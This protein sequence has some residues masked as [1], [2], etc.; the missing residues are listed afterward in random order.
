MPSPAL[1]YLELPGPAA[2]SGTPRRLAWWDW[3]A[4]PAVESGHVVLCVHGLSRQ[5]RDFDALAAVLT[6]RGYEPADITVMKRL[7]HGN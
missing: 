4:S 2:A 7:N 6:R 3:A 1:K 5:G